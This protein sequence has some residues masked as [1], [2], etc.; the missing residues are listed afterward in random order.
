MAAGENQKLKMLYLVKIFSEET[1]ET[2]AIT[3]QESID[4]LSAYGV[5]AERRTMYQDIE[6]LG[7]FGLDIIR[8]Q[9]GKGVYYHLGQRDFELPE[10]ML[11]S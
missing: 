5:N 7:Q 4:K 6:L 1:D 10:L 2:H 3:L 9:V 8:E 11:F